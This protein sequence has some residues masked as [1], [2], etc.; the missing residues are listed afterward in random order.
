MS[1]PPSSV[2]GSRSR[3]AAAGVVPLILAAVLAAC[4]ASSKPA[5]CSDVTNFKTA[6]QQLKH[7]SSPSALVT[8]VQKVASSG[9]TALT[10]VKTAYAPQTGAVKTSLATLKNSAKQLAS[11]STRSAALVAIPA[12]AQAVVTAADNLESAAKSGKCS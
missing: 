1:Q 12:Q 6:A 8:Q 10:A 2:F 5:Y 11:P 7:V 3:L 4:G 9:Q